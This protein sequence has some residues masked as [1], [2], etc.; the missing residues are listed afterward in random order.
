MTRSTSLRRSHFSY[1]PRMGCVRDR[2]WRG[3]ELTC[4]RLQLSAIVLLMLAF[5]SPA[6]A[7]PR[8]TAS[9]ASSAASASG[10]V[11]QILPSGV[12][13]RPYI[14]GEKE[15]RFGTAWLYERGVGW[16]WAGTVGGR[17]PIVRYGSIGASDPEGWQIDFD[18]AGFTRLDVGAGTVL[19]AVDF[20]AGV[21][22]TWRR[23]HTAVKG[24][25][26]HLSSHIGD[27]FLQRHPIF[28]RR[29]YV[30]DTFIGGV[31]QDL[32]AAFSVYG[33]FG[34]AVRALGGAEPYEIQFGAEY[35]PIAAGSWRGSPFA[36]I[37]VHMRQEFGTGG[38]VNASAGWQWSGTDSGTVIRTGVQYYNGK[39]LQYQFFD[40]HETL[41]GVGT[42]FGF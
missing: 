36:G 21:L 6:T 42:W 29:D 22:M 28:E 35:N 26:F 19:D 9:P 3:S 30:R 32:T 11:W 4:A 18:G 31:R 13:Y 33:E 38:N 25:F 37:N 2:L 16:I 41:L 12:L 34:Y 17:F 8:Q 20:K 5:G 1:P 14:A 40:K 10:Q 7:Y 23:G 27:E 24:G 15:S 39:A